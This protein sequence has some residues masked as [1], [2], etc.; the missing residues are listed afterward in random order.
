MP[1]LYQCSI[2]EKSECDTRELSCVKQL[3]RGFLIW[4]SVTMGCVATSPIVFIHRAIHDLTALIDG[5]PTDATVTYISILPSPHLKT[6]A[7]RVPQR[8][9][10]ALYED[11]RLCGTSL[12]RP[13]CCRRT[14]RPVPESHAESTQSR[15]YLERCWGSLRKDTAS[16]SIYNPPLHRHRPS[17]S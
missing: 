8:D 13:R 15:V 16:L 9:S 6:H 2:G 14:P 7:P 4:S 10:E 5:L 1:K 3:A 11:P 12:A 17:R